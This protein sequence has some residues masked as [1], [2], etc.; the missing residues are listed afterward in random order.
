M[1]HFVFC[2]FI[3]CSSLTGNTHAK[4]GNLFLTVNAATNYLE[5]NWDFTINCD[6]PPDSL[7]IL[8]KKD[9]F[10]TYMQTIDI[11]GTLEGY[12]LSNIKFGKPSYPG[13]WNS[14][15]PILESSCYP[16]WI[17]SQRN[18]TTIDSNCI[19]IEPAWM[20]QLGK[21]KIGNMMIPGT[22]DSGAW[23]SPHIP[24][25]TKYL[26]TQEYDLWGQ[27]VSGIRYLDIR[28]GLYQEQAW[29][30]HGVFQ[31]T[32]M[33][34]EFQ[35]LAKFL[36]LSP[37]E[38]VILHMKR[39]EIPK[40]FTYS[41]HQIILNLIQEVLG[42]YILPR[43]NFKNVYDLT[44]NEIWKTNKTL[45]VS[46]SNED[47]VSESKWLWSD[48]LHK[49]GNTNNVLELYSYLNS[50]K[51]D[52]FH[53]PTPFCALMAE[54]TPDENYIINNL[55][56]SLRNMADEVN[57]KLNV[58]LRKYNWSDLVNIVATDFFLGNDVI[59]IAI[60]TNQRRLLKLDDKESKNKEEITSNGLP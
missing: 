23:N 48:V 49:W 35:K 3:I 45:I 57:P 27:L 16:F 53:P 24:L 9:S 12:K 6:E 60:E 15:N 52:H 59:S 25:I 19:K 34:T 47:I 7:H 37:K 10:K 28:V 29:I 4:C 22:H 51:G 33:K 50:V 46:Y 38:I 1:K 55:D 43:N 56:K 17:E 30:N 13:N 14:Q 20:Q 31:C 36:S 5:F 11:N 26:L 44:L 18:G 2:V 8:Q 39:F 54:L 42:D 40:N 41:H 32:K 58:W 21:L